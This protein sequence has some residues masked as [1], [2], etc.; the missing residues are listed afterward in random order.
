MPIKC[1]TTKIKAEQTVAEIQQ[2][3]AAA[4]AIQTTIRYNDQ[5][6]PSGIRFHLDLGVGQYLPFVLAPN[7][8]GC[9]SALK[10]DNVQDKYQT[11][12]HAEKVAWRLVLNWVDVQIAFFEAHQAAALAQLFLGMGLV[13]TDQND[14]QLP[15]WKTVFQVLIEDDET[16]QRLLPSQ[17]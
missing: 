4:G 7:I 13:Q 1:Y 10:D 2:K 14:G 3:L 8:T 17:F 12:E 9:L 5:R 6:R 16:R 11:P 15:K